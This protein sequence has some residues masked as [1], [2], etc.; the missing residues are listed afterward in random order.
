[1]NAEIKLIQSPVI[2]HQIEE[3]G[4]EVTERIAALNI[5]NQVA[6]SETIQA[7]K[8]M[9]ADL[10]REAKEFEEQRKLIKDAVMNPYSEFEAIYKANI[11][12]KYK[13]ADTLLKDKINAFE[14][15][16]KA[17]KRNNLVA[18]F[19]E[20][21]EMHKI[22][23]VK[24]DGIVSDV[25]L[26]TTEKK[27]REQ[28]FQSFEKILDDLML[29]N[30]D[31]NAAEILV[32]YKVSLNA[33]QAIR[34]VRQRKESERLEK[35]RILFARTESRKRQLGHIFIYH[36]LTRTYNWI[37]DESVMVSLSDIE[38]FPAEEWSRKVIEIEARTAAKK[39]EETKQPAAEI[40]QAPVA[41]EVP[42]AEPPTKT[43]NAEE[44][45]NIEIFT[46]RFSITDTYERI[47]QLSE[48]L[49]SNNY[50][51]QNID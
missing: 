19:N 44:P 4:R 37:H 10:N 2:Q 9:R 46:A 6:T 21:C 31:P 16:L 34:N 35:E 33:T 28:I 51:Y 18:Y 1:M 43:D 29:I 50:N 48:F 32:E 23:F 36:D 26:T 30:D 3:A 47:M 39:K 25:N 17:Q 15:T 40:L 24:F 27:Y 12:E 8:S 20:L 13:E 14:M 42:K 49:K 11:I 5:N 45:A 7:L 41:V 22:D 38:N